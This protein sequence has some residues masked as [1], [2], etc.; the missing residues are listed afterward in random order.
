[1]TDKKTIDAAKK[2]RIRIQ[3]A[4]GCLDEAMRQVSIPEP[5]F[6]ACQAHIDAAQA[7]LPTITEDGDVL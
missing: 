5:D 2:A 7:T 1:M 6:V 3:T 4:R